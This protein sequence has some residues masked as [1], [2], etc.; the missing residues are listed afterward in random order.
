MKVEPWPRLLSTVMSPPI[1]RQKWR[2]I[3]SPSPVPPYRRVVEASA[4]V[5]ASKSRASCSVVMPMPVSVTAKV[6]TDRVDLARAR[7][8]AARFLVRG[9]VTFPAHAQRDGAVCR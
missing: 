1:S 3:A 8:A 9:S 7:R 5:N 4:W 6:T 2:L